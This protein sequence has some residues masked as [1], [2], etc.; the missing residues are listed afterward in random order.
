MN[1][2]EKTVESLGVDFVL[3]CGERGVDLKSEFE[4]GTSQP[5]AGWPSDVRRRTPFE[6][7]QV[8]PRLTAG[9][10]SGVVL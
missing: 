3:K 5:E 7:Y 4:I 10:T 1:V 8:Q 6:E 2:L 9:L